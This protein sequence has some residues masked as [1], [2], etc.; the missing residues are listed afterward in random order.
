MSVEHVFYNMNQHIFSYA[1]STVEKPV[2]PLAVKVVMIDLDGTLLDTTQVLW[3]SGMSYGHS[4]GNANLPT[5]LAGGRKLGW[6]HGQHL[7][8]NLP[9]IG[10]YNVADA[11]AHYKLCGRPVDSNAHLSNLFLTMLHRMDVETDQFQD[12]LRTLSEIVV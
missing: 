2:F 5:I 11:G 10:Q 6:K 4:H 7:D 9:I 3:G 8:F 12:S 1:S